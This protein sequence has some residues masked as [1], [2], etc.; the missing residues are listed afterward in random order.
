MAEANTLDVLNRLLAIEYRSLPMYLQ[1]GDTWVHRGD[2]RI[3]TTLRRIVADQ[4]EMAG[5]ISR[6]V[7]R[8]GGTPELGEPRMDFT[9]THFLALEFLVERLLREAKRGVAAVEECIDQLADDA[10]ARE[11]AQEVLG[12]Q[13]AHIE[14][15]ESVTKQ[16]A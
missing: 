12:S 10:V 3:T 7:Q 14:A 8:R 11:L 4:Q 6:L 13:R 1:G 16:P 15:L 5:R 2:E 9:D